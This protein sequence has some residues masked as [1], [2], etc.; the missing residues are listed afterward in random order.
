MTSS[1]PMTAV[2]PE[3]AT[4][5][6]RLRLGRM[7]AT[8]AERIALAEKQGMPFQDLLLVILTDEIARRDSTAAERRT[9]EARLD[10]DMTLER[11]DP[12][13]KITYDKRL[14]AE[15]TS[16]RFVEARRHLIV[17][18]PV[19][20]GKT[21]L[22]N[23]FGHLACREGHSVFFTRADAMLHTLKKSRFDN[24]REDEMLA[25]CTV[26]LL[27]V[28]D[29]ALEPMSRDESKDIYE[30]FVERTGHASTII[31]S[32]RDTSEWLA[33]FDDVLRAQSA[34]DRFKNAAYD[35]VIEGESYRPRLKPKLEESGTAKP[36]ASPAT[37]TKPRRRGR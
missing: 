28:D 4:A 2:A 9:V 33:M 31:T 19:G 25:L 11:F 32:N 30:L 17:L 20:V 22:A 3:L 35:L 27:I 24:S 21:F 34:V 37:T 8:L 6:R 18:G 5:L 29:F 12:A 15:L 36:A 23:A 10:P 1:A 16:L 7:L 14:L 26:D 13:A